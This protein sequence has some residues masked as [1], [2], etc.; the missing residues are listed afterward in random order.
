MVIFCDFNS[1]INLKNK[2]NIDNESITGVLYGFW[3]SA[4]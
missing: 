4:L 3:D 1:T 2:L